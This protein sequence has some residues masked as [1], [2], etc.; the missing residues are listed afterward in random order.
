MLPPQCSPENLAALGA[1]RKNSL[2][3]SSR[4]ESFPSECGRGVHPRPRDSCGRCRVNT[5]QHHKADIGATHG[6]MSSRRPSERR[7]QI[8]YTKTA[9]LK[10]H[11]LN[12]KLYGA[13]TVDAE[14]LASIELNG[15]L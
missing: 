8:S 10:P 7:G 3:S 1:R 5:P 13:E 12:E 4:A 11:P 14:L 15:I 2:H 9:R 6:G